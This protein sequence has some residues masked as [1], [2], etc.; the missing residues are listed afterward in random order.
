VLKPGGLFLFDTINR[1]AKSKAVMIYGLQVS[2]LTKLMPPDTHVW[3]MFIKPEELTSAL[4][5]H[6]LA[7]EDMQGSR[8]AQNPFTTLWHVTQRKQGRITFAELGR[9]L[10]LK[11]DPDL[12]AN[13]LGYARKTV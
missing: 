12:S 13:Y 9:R 8:I 2:P 3:E 10:Q 6:G 1:T 7:L 4:R 11:L 5:S